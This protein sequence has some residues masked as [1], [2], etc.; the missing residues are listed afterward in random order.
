MSSFCVSLYHRFIVS[1]LVDEHGLSNNLSNDLSCPKVCKYIEQ[2]IARR[3]Q[4]FICATIRVL[5]ASRR[6][7]APAKYYLLLV[8]NNKKER[9]RHRR[10][11]KR[12]DWWRR[13]RRGK[14]F[15][16]CIARSDDC[17]LS[18]GYIDADALVLHRTIMRR[19]AVRISS[20]DT[21]RLY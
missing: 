7:G 6:P 4:T 15:L 3:A 21:K 19:G 8:N 14:K 18:R 5:R 10:R 11:R 2:H 9:Q 13:Q 16:L 17:I 1:R 12:R 20:R